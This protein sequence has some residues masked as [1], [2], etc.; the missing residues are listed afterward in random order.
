MQREVE[1][2][3]DSV[4]RYPSLCKDECDAVQWDQCILFHEVQHTID[5][6]KRKF[7]NMRRRKLPT[8]DPLIPADVKWAKKLQYRMT[9][10]AGLGGGTLDN[11]DVLL[12]S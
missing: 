6:I 8:G 3:S 12:P 11:E 10:L 7:A 5:G 2:L 4:E 1:M 9:E